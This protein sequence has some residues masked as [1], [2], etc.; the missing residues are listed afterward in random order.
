MR[1]KVRDGTEH[2]STGTMRSILSQAHITLD[3]WNNLA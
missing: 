2:V 3:D 1:L